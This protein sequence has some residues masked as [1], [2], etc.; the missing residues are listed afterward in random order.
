MKKI[1]LAAIFAVML[2]A[3][4]T[5]NVQAQTKAVNIE[6]FGEK[7]A[8]EKTPAAITVTPIYDKA[9]KLLYTVKR[10]ESAGL[11]KEVSRMITNGFSNFDISGVEEVVLPL[12][13]NSIYFVHIANNK[14]LK[15]VK[16]Y[17]GDSEVINEYR[18]G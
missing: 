8:N 2:S 3:G 7:I 18:K 4:L 15:T 12:N 11:P 9:G 6:N 16:V 13:N 10:Y 5:L 17:N 14:N 1:S